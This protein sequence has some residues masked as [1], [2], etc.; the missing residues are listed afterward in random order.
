MASEA[1]MRAHA[2]PAGEQRE[3]YVSMAM[4][5]A[6]LAENCEKLAGESETPGEG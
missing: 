6:T 5:W 4:G 1:L 3:V 2:L